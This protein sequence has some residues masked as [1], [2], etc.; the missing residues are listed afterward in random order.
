MDQSQ[1]L[2]AY[3]Q[4][5]YASGLT[6]DQIK[7]QLLQAGWQLAMIEAAFQAPT[8]AAPQPIDPHRQRNGVLW[9]VSPFIVFV[10]II[11]L[12]FIVHAANVNSAIVNIISLL[13]GVAGVI[14]VP[15]GPTIGII[16][17]SRH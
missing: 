13:G 2:Y 17:L 15:V 5:A 11:L 1:Q 9:I 6:A 12:Q 8:G 10:T 16:K 7:S 4:Q 14:L 3:I